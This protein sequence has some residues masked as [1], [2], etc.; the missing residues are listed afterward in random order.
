MDFKTVQTSLII[1][2]IIGMMFT[3]MPKLIDNLF[4]LNPILC[5][6]L[7]ESQCETLEISTMIIFGMLL[8]LYILRQKPKINSKSN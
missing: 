5:G 6:N 7:T 2:V 4:K 8:L 3:V 1:A